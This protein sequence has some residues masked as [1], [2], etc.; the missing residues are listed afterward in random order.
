MVLVP[1]TLKI[2]LLLLLMPWLRVRIRWLS[3]SVLLLWRGPTTVLAMERLISAWA[4]LTP[5]AWATGFTT[6]RAVVMAAAWAVRSAS[7]HLSSLGA[8]GL[9]IRG[10]RSSIRTSVL[11]GT[12]RRVGRARIRRRWAVWTLTRAFCNTCSGRSSRCVQAAGGVEA[13]VDC[14]SFGGHTLSS[15]A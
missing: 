8:I 1:C 6:A 7:P 14:R 12:H 5:V 9:S 4:D 2:P 3:W 10:A 11:W 13:F 15:G